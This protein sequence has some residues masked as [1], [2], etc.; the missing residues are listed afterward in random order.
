MQLAAHRILE[1]WNHMEPESAADTI[2][3]C[4]GSAVWATLVALNRPFA[5]AEDLFRTADT[6][7]RDLS[8]EDWRQAFD[9]HPRIGETHAKA[10]ARSRA[11]SAGEQ[12]RALADD[13]TSAALAEGN[14]LYEARFGRIFIVCATGKSGAEILAILQRRLGNHPEAEVNEA[15][16][17]Q[18]QITQLRLRKWL[19]MPAEVS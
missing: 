2:L 16:E 17:Q 6:V 18:R 14:K 19:Q 4:S 7:W 9:S 15:A 10:T 12:S 3:P 1:D 11:W 13:S 8:E 5:T